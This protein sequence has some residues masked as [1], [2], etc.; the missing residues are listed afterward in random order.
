MQ[1]VL[2][3]IDGIIGLIDGVVA[4]VGMFLRLLAELVSLFAC[5]IMIVWFICCARGDRCRLISNLAW[6]LEAIIVVA[7]PIGGSIVGLLLWG[8]SYLPHVACARAGTQWFLELA[9]HLLLATIIYGIVRWLRDRN[10]C[11]V[12]VLWQWPWTEKTP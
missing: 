11:P 5:G 4:L 9:G 1:Q 2:R 7:L 3:T 6:V 8:F 12:L 10:R